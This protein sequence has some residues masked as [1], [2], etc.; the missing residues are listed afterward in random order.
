MDKR[1][2]IIIIIFI[3]GLGSMYYIVDNSNT[4]GSAITTFSKTTI[5][6]PEGFSVGDT[7]SDSVELYSKKNPEKITIYDYGKGNT[8][9]SDLKNITAL[10]QENADLTNITNKTENISDQT[11]YSIDLMDGN[12]T[13]QISAFYRQN[14][15]YVLVM[16]EFKN[17]DDINKN[18]EFIIT[19][20]TPDY[21]QAQD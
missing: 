18:L 2:L 1:W 12:G 11:V 7:S 10:Y 14:H 9:I 20:M 6:I 3:I 15:T 5:T 17:P 21:K 19:T 16:E 8:A 4:V 13:N